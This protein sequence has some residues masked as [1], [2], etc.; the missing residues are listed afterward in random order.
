MNQRQP[1]VATTEQRRRPAQ[2]RRARPSSGSWWEE[3]ISSVEWTPGFVGFLYYIFVIITYWLPGA[4]IAI[5]L[6]LV[7]I[8]M[9]PQD[10]RMCPFLWIFGAFAGWC[11]L[12]YLSS[13]Y[14]DVAWEQTNAVLKTWLIM[15]AAYNVIRTR[16][17]LRMFLAFAIACFMLFPTRGAFINHFGGY[18][19]MGRALWNFAY[20]NPNDL[21]AYA[22]LIAS[23]ACAF[24]FIVRHSSL[25]LAAVGAVG[26]L[27]LLIFYTQS[28]GALVAAGVVGLVVLIANRKNTRVLI[29]AVAL[30]GAAVIFAPKGAFDRITRLAGASASTG[31]RG[32]DSEGSAEQR[33]QLL[34]VAVAVARDNPAFGVGPGAYSIAH[35]IY[36]R[37]RRAELPAAGGNR[38]PHNTVMRTLAETGWI[39]LGL[40]VAMIAGAWARAYAVQR[41]LRAFKKPSDPVIRYLAFGLLAY[42][43]AGLFGSF[44]YLNVLY[45]QIAL[46]EVAMTLSKGTMPRAVQSAI[47]PRERL[48]PV[49]RRASLRD[50]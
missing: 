15:F 4:D 50:T 44:T 3:L 13:V 28:R 24:F 25:R 16:A 12:S 31:F 46:L 6:V 2:V 47:A 48:R 32:A 42:M 11:V 18:N 34:Q 40:F 49:L 27:L 17:Q 26:A 19:V 39:G 23:M 8:L 22:L 41:Q 36:A 37:A 43:I 7:S 10:W 1:A 35:G 38:D 21:A 29:G 20:A 30:T 33:Y 14:K 5:V 45:L 9:R